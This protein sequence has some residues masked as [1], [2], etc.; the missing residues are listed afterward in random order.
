MK[1][2]TINIKYNVGDKVWIMLHNYPTC[3][4]VARVSI[5]GGNVSE[6]GETSNLGRV[7][8]YLSHDDWKSF[9]EDELCDSFEELRDKVF[10]D[11]MRE[12]VEP[13]EE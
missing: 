4:K 8:Y 1:T 6:E 10:C 7:T 13:D 5:L 9:S 2:I 12:N 3:L 11:E